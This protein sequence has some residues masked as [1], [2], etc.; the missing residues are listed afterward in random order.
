[1]VESPLI[2]LA[3]LFPFTLNGL[4]TDEGVMMFL[5]HGDENR[6]LA[7]ALIYRLILILVPALVG[8]FVWNLVKKK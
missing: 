4:G 1:M 5:F 8:L 3:R 2:T 6:I 7:G